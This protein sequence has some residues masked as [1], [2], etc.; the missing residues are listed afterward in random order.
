MSASTPASGN[1]TAR[2]SEVEAVLKRRRA[3]ESLQWEVDGLDWP[4]REASRF[5]EAGGIRWHVQIMG[6]GPVVLLLHGT[7][8]SS[9]SWRALAPLLAKRH[10]VLAPDLPG[11]G[12]TQTP[13]PQRLSLTGMAALV[14][15]LL[16]TLKLDPESVVGH[17]AGAA[18]AA[19]MCLDGAMAPRSLISINGAL[20]P[21]AGLPGWVYSPIA[22][23]LARG[24]FWASLMARGAAERRAVARL[25]ERTGS[26]IEPRGIDLYHRLLRTKRHTTAALGMMAHWDL[27]PL[28]RELSGLRPDLLLV[29]GENDLMIPPG[30]AERLGRV[31]PAARLKRLAGCGHLLHEERPEEAAALIEAHMAGAGEGGPRP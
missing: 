25:I 16:R 19:R 24:G 8:A 11:H 13:A 14:E 15:S 27:V 1:E 20:L 7:A 3:R 2:Y 5:V 17:S 31:L 10:T 18:I 22:R 21:L 23:L 4:N 26:K 30:Q 29:A 6:R 12:F 9:H 28:R